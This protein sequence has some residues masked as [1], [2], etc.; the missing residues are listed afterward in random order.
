M[1]VKI[2]E[3]VS[4]LSNKELKK[5]YEAL[6]EIIEICSNPKDYIF[7][8]ELEHEIEERGLRIKTEVVINE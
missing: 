8:M 7:L 5:E 4:K 1:K 2:K 6:N 3:Y